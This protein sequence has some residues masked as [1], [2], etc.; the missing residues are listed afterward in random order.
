MATHP[1]NVPAVPDRTGFST[2]VADRIRGVRDK[3]FGPLEPRPVVAPTGSERQ[4]DYPVGS[5]LRITPRSDEKITFGH[6]RTLADT[7]DL[8]R[9]VIETRKDQMA[10]LEWLI[11][12]KDT[13]KETPDSVK[14]MEFF[15]Q[16]DR[17]HD[18]D[19]WLRAIME[20]VYV[21]D[22]PCIEPRFTKGGELYSLDQIDGSTINRLID[23]EGRVPVPPSP[24]YQQI[25]KGIP[26][27]NFT[28][29]E[30]IY[31]P[32]NVRVHKMYGFSHVEQILVTICIALRRQ[33]F[34]LEYYTE[35][36]IP[37][38]FATTPETW[39]LEQIQRYQV[40]WD[41]F[42]AGDTAERRKMRFIPH[43]SDYIPTKDAKLHD[44][45]DEWLARI[46]AYTFSIPATPFIK[47][48]NRAT[49]ETSN[50]SSL[51]EGIEPMKRW[52]SNM[53]NMVIRRYL[54]RPDLK[55]VW[56]Y[57][58]SLD[59]KKQAEIHQIYVVSSIMTPNE[60]RAEIGLGKIEGGD[61]LTRD[62]EAEMQTKLAKQFPEKN[63]KDPANADSG[64]HE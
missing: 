13:K 28:F 16:P 34:Q 45:H 1:T 3:W 39:S 52:I 50:I 59:R 63:R 33:G 9:I 30:L 51:E 6:L 40:Y 7:L 56:K 62:L 61:K 48:M 44:D 17:I 32:R 14:A 64:T 18:W 26:A 15:E 41:T 21:I 47:Q 35:G 58:A 38:A 37:D 5:N 12:D 60:A 4:F 46:V 31:R 42:I 53:M 24:A 20:D 10:R 23:G 2:R 8:V 27:A 25:I 29:D 57:E 54:G 55:F 36:N 11:V 43:G 19:T 22:A 49:A